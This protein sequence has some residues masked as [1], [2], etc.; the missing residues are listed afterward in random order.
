[1]DPKDDI[2]TGMSPQ[3]KLH[4]RFMVDQCRQFEYDLRHAMLNRLVLPSEWQGVFEKEPVKGTTRVTIRL[5][6]DLVRFFRKFGPGWQKVLNTVVRAFV[7]ARLS[8]I[9]DGPGSINELLDGLSERPSVG[10]MER[11]LAELRRQCD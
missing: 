4:Y 3:K 6:E 2:T 9:L 5:D 7:K 10:E 11:M 1:M 8:G